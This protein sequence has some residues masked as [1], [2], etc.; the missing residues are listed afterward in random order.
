MGCL[1]VTEQKEQE[2]ILQSSKGVLP[3]M[4]NHRALFL[5]YHLTQCTPTLSTE[6]NDS[7]NR[8]SPTEIGHHS[9]KIVLDRYKDIFCFDTSSRLS[10][11]KRRKGTFS[12]PNEIKVKSYHQSKAKSDLTDDIVNS[13]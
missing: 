3:Y 8:I 2:L 6:P 9:S 4:K 12:K 10:Y 7:S 1:C 11:W 13:L 5:K